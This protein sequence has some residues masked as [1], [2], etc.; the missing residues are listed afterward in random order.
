MGPK[1]EPIFNQKTKPELGQESVPG[2]PL[3]GFSLVRAK[4]KPKRRFCWFVFSLLFACDQI[5]WSS[6]LACFELDFSLRVA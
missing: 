3:G 4:E 1:T 5:V 2:G 6:V